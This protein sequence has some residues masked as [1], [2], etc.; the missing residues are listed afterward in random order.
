MTRVTFGVSSSFAA[1]MALK[2]NAIDIATEFPSAAE[3]VDKSF[4]VD[5]CLTGANSIP[6]ATSLQVELNSLF[7][8][9]EFPL[10][11]WNSSEL[12]VLRKIPPELKDTSAT[13]SLPSV[14][15]YTKTLG[16]EWNTGMD[17]FRITIANLP[18]LDNITKRV[19]VSDIAKI[20]EIL[21]FFSPA[22]VKVKILL[23]RLWEQKVEW[24][25]KVP[26]TIYDDWLQ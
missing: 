22:V 14:D 3:V 2:K 4:Y 19:L 18:P 13:Q 10:R 26:R 20:Y 6:E 11:K 9:G 16:I 15:E 7:S 8:K 23:Q 1:N 24:D 5:D 25:D 21:G 17:H 12:E